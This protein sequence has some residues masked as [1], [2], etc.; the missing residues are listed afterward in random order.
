M[1][2]KVTAA[3]QLERL[4]GLNFTPQEKSQKGDL[5]AA[6][7][8]AVTEDIAKSVVDDWLAESTDCPKPAQLRRAI[9]ARQ[10]GLMEQRRRCHFC[11]GTGFT[12]RYYLATYHGM[13][14]AQLR[15][16]HRIEGL[17]ESLRMAEGLRN[18]YSSPTPPTMAQ[19][20]ISA[21]AECQCRKV[22]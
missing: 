18:A 6:M 12:T 14:F 21:A 13:S 9:N 2:D 11:G 10:E 16:V 19:Q 7:Q 4:L 22:A 20:V 15:G 1:I 8:V 5:L 3:R 17:E